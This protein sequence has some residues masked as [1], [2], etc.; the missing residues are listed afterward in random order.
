M[1][2]SRF[3]ALLTVKCMVRH[4]SSLFGRLLNCHL[5]RSAA[6]RSSS[7]TR[8]VRVVVQTASRIPAMLDG[9]HKQVP[10]DKHDSSMSR[11]GRGARV[12]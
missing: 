10:M 5:L 3:R 12:R 7:L 2:I 1:Q 8:I 9:A 6:H 4:G 11:K